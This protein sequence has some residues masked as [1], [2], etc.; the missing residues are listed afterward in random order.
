MI[1]F[2][3]GLHVV[4]I[5]KTLLINNNTQKRCSLFSPSLFFLLLFSLL[6]ALIYNMVS[7]RCS[8]QLRIS[9]SFFSLMIMLCM[10]QS[11]LFLILSSFVILPYILILMIRIV[12]LYQFFPHLIIFIFIITVIIIVIFMIIIIIF[13]LCASSKHVK[14][15]KI[16][17]C[18]P[19]YY[20]E[21]S[22]IFNIKCWNTF[23]MQWFLVIPLKK[24][25]KHLSN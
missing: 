25:I 19:W 14:C 1:C 10:S 23:S 24:E 7:P 6:L 15:C 4:S 16:W 20:K 3:Y 2:F 8:G 9:E 13:I 22:L 18:D 21:K 17:I 5:N 12:W 11:R